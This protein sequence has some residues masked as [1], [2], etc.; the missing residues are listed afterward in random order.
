MAL[1]QVEVND[2]QYVSQEMS[3]YTEV[4]NNPKGSVAFH[5]RGLFLIHPSYPSQRPCSPL[6]HLHWVTQADEAPPI[7]DIASLM[8][9]RNDRWQNH[10]LALNA[11]FL[12]WHVSLPTTCCWPKQVTWL[13]LSWTRQG[14]KI[15]HQGR[16][17]TSDTKLDISGVG[18]Y[19]LLQGGKVNMYV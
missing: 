9:V 6:C 7:W 13:T 16:H 14:C 8:A 12:R 2:I 4:T 5:S 17:H 11:S 3:G 1:G 19:N 10:E 18:T 15:L